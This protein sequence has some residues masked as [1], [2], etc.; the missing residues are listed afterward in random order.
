MKHAAV[1]L[2]RAPLPLVQTAALV[3]LILSVMGIQGAD[4]PDVSWITSQMTH[5]ERLLG[6]PFV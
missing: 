1:Q 2:P 6:L 3:V 4:G 5:P